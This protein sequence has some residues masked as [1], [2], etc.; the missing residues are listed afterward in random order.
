LQSAWGFA[1]NLTGALLNPYKVAVK[2][3]NTRRNSFGSRG[4]LRHSSG[5]N[6]C[7][8]RLLSS[9]RKKSPGIS[10]R[11]EANVTQDSLDSNIPATIRCHGT[12]GG[13]AVGPLTVALEPIEIWKDWVVLISDPGD[14]AC[15]VFS[16]GGY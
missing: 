6:Y 2:I 7:H 5:G 13:V 4:L 10:A 11:L 8:P 3:F 16:G 15:L 14:A 9:H 12:A 1:N